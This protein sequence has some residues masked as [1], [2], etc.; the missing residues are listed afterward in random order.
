MGAA[1]L[2]QTL[3][4]RRVAAPAALLARY[5][6][7]GRVRWRRG[8]L[9]VFIAG[10]FLGQ[11]SA[12]AITLWRTVFLSPHAPVDAELLLH[13]LRHVH[14]FEASFAFPLLYLW[15]SARRGYFANRFEADARDYAA[16]RLRGTK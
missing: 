1:A 10:W 15:E 2:V 9:P 8:G 5:P 4:G 3:I 13:E 7:L 12:A 11:R 16:R 14:Q 6:E